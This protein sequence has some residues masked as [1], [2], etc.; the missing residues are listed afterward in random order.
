MDTIIVYTL[1]PIFFLAL[2]LV[3]LFIAREE[4]KHP[5]TQEQPEKQA[6]A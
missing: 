4:E 6:E 1:V 5:G 2:S 3:V